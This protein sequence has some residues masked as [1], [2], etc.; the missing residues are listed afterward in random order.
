MSLRAKDAAM[1]R[2]DEYRK[3]LRSTLTNNVYE[4]VTS[5]SDRTT[6]RVFKKKQRKEKPKKKKQERERERIS[7]IQLTER[8]AL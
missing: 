8:D 1:Q 3:S 6:E 5:M 7:K 2:A 4:K